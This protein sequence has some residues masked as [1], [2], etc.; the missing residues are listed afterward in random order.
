LKKIAAVW[1]SF[2]VFAAAAMGLCSAGPRETGLSAR[3]EVSQGPSPQAADPAAQLSAS[4]EF[5]DL[6]I[7]GAPVATARQCIAYL[8]K[9]NSLPLISVSIEELVGIFYEEGAREGV[10]PDVAFAQSILET[11][12]FRFG[13][14]VYPFQNNYAGIGATGGGA[15]GAVFPSPAIGVRSQMQHLLAYASIRPPADPIVDPRYEFV[16]RN[17]QRHG[18]I[19]TWRALSGIWAVPGQNYGD[20]ILKIHDEIVQMPE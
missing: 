8:S 18:M 7:L 15:S 9:K 5:Y 20:K 19:T 17:P 3:L 12:Y 1:I 2:I 13:G 16:A 6:T 10:R 4:P 11:G 14:D